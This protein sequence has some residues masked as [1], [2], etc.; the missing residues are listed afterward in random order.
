YQRHEDLTWKRL[1]S[2]L[3]AEGVEKSEPVLKMRHL[4]TAFTNGPL[5]ADGFVS[6]RQDMTVLCVKR[7]DVNYD[8]L[9][10]FASPLCDTPELRKRLLK[11]RGTDGPKPDP[12]TPTK[13]IDEATRAS[14]ALMLRALEDD[15]ERASVSHNASRQLLFASGLLPTNVAAPEWIQ[16]GMG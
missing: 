16:F 6:R 3:D 12:M 7:T 14:L 5:V 1:S 13:P 9:D 4:H 10:R 2:A 11:L 8:V 15:A